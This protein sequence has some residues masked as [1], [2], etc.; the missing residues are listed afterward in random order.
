[1]ADERDQKKVAHEE[2]QRRRSVGG[3][4]LRDRTYAM[5]VVWVACRKKGSAV[6]YV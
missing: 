3:G 1:V 2:K 5:R 6:W 4:W